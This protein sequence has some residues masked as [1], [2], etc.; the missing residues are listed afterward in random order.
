VFLTP[1]CSTRL[2]E[3]HDKNS[4]PYYVIKNEKQIIVNSGSKKK[5][6]KHRKKCG[7]S[8]KAGYY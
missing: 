5:I 3:K 8:F 4:N 2:D 7:E 1:Y 6:N